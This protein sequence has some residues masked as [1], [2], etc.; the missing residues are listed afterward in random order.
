MGEEGGGIGK[1]KQKEG[2]IA[3][4]TVCNVARTFDKLSK[5]PQ[6]K[7]ERRGHR[8]GIEAKAPFISL[9]RWS[10]RREGK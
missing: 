7:K 3:S 9:T 2:Q 8:R 5:G 4:P 6:K 10:V 1:A